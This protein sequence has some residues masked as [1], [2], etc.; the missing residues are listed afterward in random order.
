MEPINAYKIVN[1]MSENNIAI[2]SGS[3]C[4]SSSDKPS[5]TLASIGCNKSKLFSNIRL[6]FNDEN[7]YEELD[8]F[9]CLIL[10]CI[11]IF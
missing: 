2:S 9:Y 11:D 10:D 7:T 3:A 8:K 6:S 1:Y 5:S 4:S